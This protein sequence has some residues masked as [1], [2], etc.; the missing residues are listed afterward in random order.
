MAHMLI[1]IDA[2]PIQH[3]KIKESMN[4]RKY[5]LKKFR[6][7]YNIP[8]ISEVRF[9]NIRAKKEIVPFILRDL[10]ARS[11]LDPKH[12]TDTITQSEADQQPHQVKK[13]PLKVRC[14]IWI[15][16]RMLKIVG[17]SPAPTWAKGDINAFVPGWAYVYCF[18][19]LKDLETN[20]GEWL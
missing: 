14:M 11:I 7:G 12:L 16:K 20:Y 8:H 2:D 15:L 17:I 19:V 3:E 1:A 4:N 9:Y 13:T 18:G 6:A 5:G 10:K